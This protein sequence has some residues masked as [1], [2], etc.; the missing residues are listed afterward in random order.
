MSPITPDHA[1]AP[2]IRGWVRLLIA[3]V[4]A[5]DVAAFFQWAD[6]A[7]QSEFGG[8]RDEASHYLAGLRV[9][10]A[11]RR[12][13]DR[14]QT[15]QHPQAALRRTSAFDIAE[16]GWMLIFGTSRITVLLFMAVLAAATATLIFGVLQRE[17]GDWAATAAS[18]VWL[19]APVVRESY[20]TLLPVQFAALVLTAAVL[21][22]ARLV[23]DGAMRRAPWIGAAAVAGGA[24]GLAFAGAVAL[25]FA[26]GDPRTAL[27]FLKECTSVSGIAAAAFAIAGAV[28]RP[29]SEMRVSAVWVALTAL[30]TGV[31]FARWMQAGVPDTRVLI[32]A[33]PA[34]AM[35]AVRGAVLLAGIVGARRAI[36]AE[37]SRRR[38]LWILLL[39]LL[40]LPPALLQPRQKDWHGF[41]A[42]ALTLVEE[43][44][45]EARVLVVSDSLGEGMLISETAMRDSARQI[46]IERGSES[47]TDPAVSMPRGRPAER[48]LEDRQVLAHLTSGSI[49]YVVLDTAVPEDTRAGYHDQV[50]RVIE[51]NIRNFWPICDCPVIRDGEPQG[52]PLRIFRVM[53]SDGAELPSQ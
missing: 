38:A 46:V 29:P 8:H 24:G 51:D 53:K 1:P 9:R 49:R 28:I 21:L 34:L 36:A 22:G 43:A 52:H 3:F 37:G 32:A 44:H 14:S 19:C 20:E 35:L 50:R 5:F 33:T 47:L 18:L 27:S 7:F 11:V 25:G 6:G 15:L 17:M 40:V 4:V 26:P 2:K 30:V 42:A 23:G 39:V 16:G 10:D 48:Y 13:A 31:V 12:V 45:G 41:G